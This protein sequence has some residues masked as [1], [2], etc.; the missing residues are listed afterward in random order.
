MMS[1]MLADLIASP[2]GE[3]M[4]FAKLDFSKDVFGYP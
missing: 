2:Q 1:A 3:R 4:F